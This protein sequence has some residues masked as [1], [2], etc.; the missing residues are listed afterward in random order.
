MRTAAAL[1]LLV[2]VAHRGYR[3]GYTSGIVVGART[4][5]DLDLTPLGGCCR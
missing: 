1:L 3:R 2:L 5:S 4:A